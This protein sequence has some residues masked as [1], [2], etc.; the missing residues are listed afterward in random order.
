MS[1]VLDAGD[2]DARDVAAAALEEG[3]LV[4]VP[5][6]TVYGIAARLD[7][8][9]GLAAIFD[10]KRRPAGLA[11]P[12]LVA[13]LDQARALAPVDERA[14]TLAAAF[15]PGALTMVLPRHP[16]LAADLGGDGISVG[17]RVPRHPA[18]QLLLAGTGPLATSSAN[19]SGMPTPATV[20]EIESL[21][22][23]AVAVYLDAGPAAAGP[24]STVV[25]LTGPSPVLLREG[26][27]SLAQILETLAG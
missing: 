19:P 13:D 12:V 8:P 3:R 20:R 9:A 6:D 26:P 11:L 16:A 1:P 27:V 23:E 5:T 18:L 25:G 15:W 24:A 10:T 17:I 4:V 22:G 21:F 2:P 7:R 14:V